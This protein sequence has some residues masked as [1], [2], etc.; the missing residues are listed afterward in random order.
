MDINFKIFIIGG[1]L[2]IFIKFKKCVLIWFI[3][4]MYKMYFKDLVR[5]LWDLLEYCLMVENC[6]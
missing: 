6:K 4:F 1:E 3:N 2:E 5:F